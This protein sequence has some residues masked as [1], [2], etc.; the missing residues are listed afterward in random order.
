MLENNEVLYNV[1]WGRD[2]TLSPKLVKLQCYKQMGNYFYTKTLSKNVKPE[3][4]SGSP[5]FDENGYLVGIASG[6]EGNLG[7]VGSVK[8]LWKMFDSYHVDY[9]IP[10]D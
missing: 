3:G 7:I 8:Y 6:G 1:G 2:D 10:D 9:V 5:V 4:R